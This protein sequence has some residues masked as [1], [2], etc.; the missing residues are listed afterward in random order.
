MIDKDIIEQLNKAR[1]NPIR[2]VEVTREIIWDESVQFAKEGNEHFFEKLSLCQE[3]GRYAV[4]QYDGGFPMMI[5]MRKN[6]ESDKMKVTIV[7]KHVYDII[8]DA[9][10]T[11]RLYTHYYVNAYEFVLVY[12]LTRHIDL[13][14]YGII[15]L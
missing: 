10:E 4:V 12:C 5:D 6:N 7:D 2:T 14:E 13:V 9:I 15:D 11:Y 1:Q 8:M 3:E